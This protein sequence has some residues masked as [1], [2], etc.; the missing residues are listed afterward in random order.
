MASLWNCGRHCGTIGKFHMMEIAEI[1]RSYREGIIEEWVRRLHDEVSPA[2]TAQPIESLYSTVS[3]A[4]DANFAALVNNDY[5]KIDEAV[6]EIGRLR[7]RAGF[8]LSDVQKAFELYRSIVVPIFLAESKNTSRL[9]LFER[10]NACLSYTIH[11]FSDY[12]QGLS[13]KQIRGYAQTLEIKVGERTKE[14]A[15]SVAKY[16]TLVEEIRDGYFVNKRGKMVYANRAFCEMHGY[17][18]KEVIGRYYTD[19]VAPESLEEIKKIYEKR[20]DDGESKNSTSIIACIRTEAVS[21]LRTRLPSRIT[22]VV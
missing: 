2:Y 21:L 9:Q 7:S 19:F 17:T 1:L 4:A 5:S 6:E 11:K 20:I 22:R 18:L 10:L 14:L 16:R 3:A 13:E 15:Q 12:F 8:P